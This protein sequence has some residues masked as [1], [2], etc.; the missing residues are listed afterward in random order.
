M[1][2]GTKQ[3]SDLVLVGVVTA[4][5]GVRGLVKV[6]SFTEEPSDMV[7]YGLLSDQTGR[8]TFQ[9]DIVGEAKGQLIVRMDGI[10]DRNAAED[11]KGQKLF[12]HRSALPETEEDEFYHA[13]L[14]GLRTVLADGSP[15][16]LIKAV[17]DFGAGDLLEVALDDAGMTYLP[18]TRE[19]VPTIDLVA[20]TATVIPPT[21][22]DAVEVEGA[23]EPDAQ[24]EDA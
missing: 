12:I 21:E 15:H 19:V 2:D 23:D 9:M 11:L 22:V 13:D 14:I 6:K 1:K 16:G 10:A 24:G 5:H 3:A 17:Y 18:F 4:P 8:K 20:G 7:A